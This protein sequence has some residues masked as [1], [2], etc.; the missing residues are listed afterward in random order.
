MGRSHPAFDE[1]HHEALKAN[2]FVEKQ[3]APAAPDGARQRRVAAVYD[4]ERSDRR[5][6]AP[7]RRTPALI[8]RRYDVG[9]RAQ[10]KKLQRLMASAIFRPLN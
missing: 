9:S 1:V 4:R 5:K 7:K 3:F 8:E 10:L 2:Q 6:A